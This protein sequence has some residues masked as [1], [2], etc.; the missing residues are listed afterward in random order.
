M[1]LASGAQHM[2][3]MEQPLEVL[4]FSRMGFNAAKETREAMERVAAHAHRAKGSFHRGV[5]HPMSEKSAK[6]LVA[7]GQQLDRLMTALSE[8]SMDL[9]TDFLHYQKRI[10]EAEAALE[11]KQ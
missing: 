5:R 2:E 10:R 3:K 9:T 1:Q 7:V 8:A 11:V 4:K 6:S